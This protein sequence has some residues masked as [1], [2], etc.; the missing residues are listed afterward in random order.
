MY[1]N[2]FLWENLSHLSDLLNGLQGA[3]PDGTGAN[4]AALIRRLI[5]PGCNPLEDIFL[6]WVG[7]S[8]AGYAEVHRDIFEPISELYELMRRVTTGISH[9]IGAFG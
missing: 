9:I 4:N 1:V 7:D 3:V 6:A 8:L 5:Q 2:N